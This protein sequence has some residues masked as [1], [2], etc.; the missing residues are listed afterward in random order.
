[1]ADSS[2]NNK[3]LPW[4][5]LILGGCFALYGISVYHKHNQV[6]RPLPN[7]PPA[8]VVPQLSDIAAY[9]AEAKTLTEARA[10]RAK[11]L[12]SERK[13]TLREAGLGRRRYEAV[14]VAQDGAIAFM[15]TGLD[16]RFNADDPAK[17]RQ[18][19]E[20]V[21]RNMD[22]FVA[23]VNRHE[24][25]HWGQAGNPLTDLLEELR[26][27]LDGVAKANEAAILKIQQALRACRLAEWNNL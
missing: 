10:R 27:W 13:L 7:G 19:L 6:V 15:D 2:D 18:K 22:E 1:M 24:E 3:W 26:K 14:Q 8:P 20:A 9:L 17:I 5:L 25:Q 16:R 21:Q 11:E 4:V 23:W 12:Q